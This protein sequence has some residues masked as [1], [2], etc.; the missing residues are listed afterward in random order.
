MYQEITYE[1]ADPVATITL[2][3]PKYANAWTIRMSREVK[4]ALAQAERD[5]H[6]VG[7][8]ITG[9]GRAFCAG[10]DVSAIQ[11][12]TRGKSTE[13]IANDTQKD[14]SLTLTEEPGDP[15]FPEGFR[16]GLA[17]MISIK[18]P[19]I[20]A[21]NGPCIGMAF[22]ISLFC[23]FRFM[24]EDGYIKSAFA[25]RGLV[26]EA[27][28]SWMLS[29]LVGLD[30]ALDI[31][32]ASLKITPQEALEMGLATKVFPADTLIEESENYI[33][34]LAERC[35]PQSI[36]LMKRQVFSDL[37]QSMAE[38]AKETN[39]LMKENHKSAALKEGM[40]A[41]MEK[42]PPNFERVT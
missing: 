32:Y 30:R 42:R 5:P 3:R 29:R 25:E 23:D 10:A 20:A 24:S 13:D 34:S 33:K 19:I 2:N 17:S 6:V 21:I 16:K 14:E 15:L 1:V 31:L 22:S 35:A 8:I 28:A 36:A 4:H 37:H 18:K 38:G 26:A 11:N 12:L 39:A 40:K 9:A 7:I 27:S 41:F